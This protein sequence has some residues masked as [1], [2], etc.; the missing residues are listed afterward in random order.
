[1]AL[2]LQCLGGTSCSSGDQADPTLKEAASEPS[3]LPTPMPCCIHPSTSVVLGCCK[4]TT[5]GPRYRNTFIDVDEHDE[6]ETERRVSAFAN[7]WSN[8]VLARCWC[9]AVAALRHV[10]TAHLQVPAVAGT[11]T[12]TCTRRPRVSK[13]ITEAVPFESALPKED[14]M[15]G[16]VDMLKQKQGDASFSQKLCKKVPVARQPMF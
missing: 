4:S 2:E 11:Q 3:S 10:H 13:A 9:R 6:F 8:A 1:M 7:S 16:Y 12:W 14:A 15:R 5:N